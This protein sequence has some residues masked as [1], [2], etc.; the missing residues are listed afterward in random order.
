LRKA[1]DKARRKEIENRYKEGGHKNTR[2]NETRK[3][4]G[5]KRNGLGC[6]GGKARR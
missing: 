1:V 2:K 4:K 3:G 6:K 5:K